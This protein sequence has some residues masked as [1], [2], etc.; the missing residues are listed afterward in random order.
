LK[1]T[2]PLLLGLVLGI[3]VAAAAPPAPNAPPPVQYVKGVVLTV[4]PFEE[5]QSNQYMREAREF[6]TIKITSGPEAG[7]VMDT[8]NYV[9]ERSP[10]VIKVQPGDKIIVA[11]ANDRGRIAY[12]ISDFDRFDYVYVLL[13][14]F[15]GCLVVFAGVVGVK[16]IFV[17]GFSTAL[18]FFVYINQV[19]ARHID[20]TV[21]TLLVCA[22]IATVTQTVISGWNKKTL[23]ACTAPL[24]VDTGIKTLKTTLRGDL[25]WQGKCR[26]TETLV[27]N[28]RHLQ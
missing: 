25:F 27:R 18:I 6:V 1:R 8:F 2:V 10:Y 21:L 9:S 14:L 24:K 20:L 7:N 4:T 22:V 19:L 11:V 13:A 5:A 23:A 16:T 17:V 28:T 12:H 15:V 26:N 3:S